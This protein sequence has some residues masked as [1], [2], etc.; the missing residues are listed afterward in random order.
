[1]ICQEVQ[2][3]LFELLE[4]L[5]AEPHAAEMRAHVQT[6][7]ACQ[8]EWVASQRFAEFWKVLSAESL[9]GAPWP[10]EGRPHLTL[11]ELWALAEYAGGEIKPEDHS[12][13]EHMLEC[14]TCYDACARLRGLLLSSEA[15]EVP[16]IPV[17]LDSLLSARQAMQ[18]TLVCQWVGTAL[19]VRSAA[20]ALQQRARGSTQ[21]ETI[22]QAFGQYTVAVTLRAD[23]TK[24]KT[25]RMDLALTARS[26]EASLE[27]IRV[28][29]YRSG[30]GL[31]GSRSFRNARTEFP[32]LPIGDYHLELVR[33]E[34]LI[35][36][37]DLP[38]S[39]SPATS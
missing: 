27:G 29:L 2:E 5:I 14:R 28:D 13:W 26:P 33:D 12:R 8:R 4:G 31:V 6:C 22:E 35:G 1:M 32:P 15:H 34:A 11:D 7:A 18:L 21:G 37:I 16:D 19:V 38:I 39:E 20:A 10:P 23:T 24:K 30:K 25:C 36:C 9:A 3:N 17:S